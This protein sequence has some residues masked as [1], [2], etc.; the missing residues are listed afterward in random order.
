M[1]KNQIE[2]AGLTQPVK[3]HSEVHMFTVNIKQAMSY[4][5]DIVVE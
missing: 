5:E 1:R 2:T 3:V 4:Y